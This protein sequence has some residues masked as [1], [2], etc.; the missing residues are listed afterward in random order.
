MKVKLGITLY[1][2]F[3]L[4]CGY[5]VCMSAWLFGSICVVQRGTLRRTAL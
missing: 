5:T 1:A 2:K 3:A 4:I